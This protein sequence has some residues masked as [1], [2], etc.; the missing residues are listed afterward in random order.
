[1]G[2]YLIILGLIDYFPKIYDALLDKC[3]V[4]KGQCLVKNYSLLMDFSLK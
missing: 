2:H 1:M 4:V 3:C